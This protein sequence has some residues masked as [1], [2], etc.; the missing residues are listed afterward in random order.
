[1]SLRILSI[2]SALPHSEELSS[3][4][5]R[6]AMDIHR[7]SDLQEGLSLL[8]RDAFDVAVV[9]QRPGAPGEDGVQA[10]C[11]VRQRHLLPLLI[12]SP[13]G[14]AMDLVA[15]LDLEASDYIVEPF[16]PQE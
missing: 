9:G 8:T 1:M 13:S 3:R 11:L 12:I 16:T 4:F 5:A 2:G 15:R 10:A 7:A 6:E 14:E